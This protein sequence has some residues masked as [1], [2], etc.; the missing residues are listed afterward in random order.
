MKRYVMA[1]RPDGLADIV[2]EDDLEPHFKANRICE[3]WLNRETPADQSDPADPVADQKMNHEPPDGGAVFRMLVFPPKHEAPEISPEQMVE[4]HK[5][6]HSV[7]I[8]SIE[9][10]RTAKHPT[11]HRTDTLNYFVLTEGEIWSLSEGK[12]VLLKAG[13]VMIQR[14]CMHGWRND[15]DKRA[16]LAAILIDADAPPKPR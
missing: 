16:V 9:Y 5:A 7:H 14:G 3:L 6:I 4:M 2:F 13:D 15:S 10:L 12:D 1:N 8:P 11:M